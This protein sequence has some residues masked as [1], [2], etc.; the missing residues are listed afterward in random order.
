M[1]PANDPNTACST[2]LQNGTQC[3]LWN[4]N[5]F[6]FIPAKCDRVHNQATQFRLLFSFYLIRDYPPY[7][8]HRVC[9]ALIYSHNITM[10]PYLTVGRTLIPSSK[11][12]H[13]SLCTES[14]SLLCLPPPLTDVLLQLEHISWWKKKTPIPSAKLSFFFFF[15]LKT[16]QA[17]RITFECFDSDLRTPWK[18]P[19][20]LA[21]Q[22]GLVE[23]KTQSISARP[24]ADWCRA[25]FYSPQNISGASQQNS[26][27]AF[28]ETTEVDGDFFKMWMIQQQQQNVKWN[29]SIQ[30]FVHPWLMLMCLCF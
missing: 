23:I 28:S 9:L 25:K 29:S 18:H 24:R 2:P 1:Y 17:F 13:H 20:S 16:V 12:S 22:N 11:S 19:S 7:L 15:F 30:T 3:Q 5:K 8:Q 4:F 26:A 6:E 27:A 14:H 21:I 10:P